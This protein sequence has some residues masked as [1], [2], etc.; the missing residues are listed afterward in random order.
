MGLPI[1]VDQT[2]LLDVTTEA[3]RAIIS[4]KSAILLQRG[5]V[6]LKFQVEGVAPPTILLLHSKLG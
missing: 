1:S 5:P 2:F 4:S 3:L 6:D